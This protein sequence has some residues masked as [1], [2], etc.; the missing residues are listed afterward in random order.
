MC[1]TPHQR[2]FACCPALHS[3]EWT[4]RFLP[5][6]HWTPPPP[7][8]V[9]HWVGFWTSGAISQPLSL[10]QHLSTHFPLCCCCSV[11]TEGD[12]PLMSHWL[13]RLPF[14]CS[15]HQWRNTKG[16]YGTVWWAL[17]SECACAFCFKSTLFFPLCLNVTWNTQTWRVNAVKKNL[18][19]CDYERNYLVIFLVI[20]GLCSWWR[21]CCL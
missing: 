7:D 19:S 21:D 9:E 10:P 13:L 20:V 18:I 2:V 17:H 5:E 14:C 11:V 3:M 12:S 16:L 4:C 15:G 6:E 8:P 1:L